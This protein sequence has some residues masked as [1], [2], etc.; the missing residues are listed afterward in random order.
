MKKIVHT[1]LIIAALLLLIGGTFAWYTVSKRTAKSKPVEIAEPY[2]LTLRD[3]GDQ[4]LQQIPIGNLFLGEKKQ[5]VYSVSSKDDDG[6]IGSTFDYAMELIYTENLPLQYEIYQLE[7]VTEDY[8]NEPDVL[9]AYYENTQTNTKEV[10]YYRKKQTLLS[11][12]DISVKRRQEA[13][14]TD[15][16]INR[17]VYTEYTRDADGQK[18]HLGNTEDTCQ[19]YFLLEMQWEN[20]V[21]NISKYEKETD[22][23]YIV[24]RSLES[25]DG[26]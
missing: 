8:K 2:Q 25:M 5:V 10:R 18:L 24:A 1:G 4:V 20:V 21:T 7:A 14:V 19:Q 12:T 9:P 13:G 22:M 17:G 3:A 11:G 26:N 15:T 6:T 16:I 23:I